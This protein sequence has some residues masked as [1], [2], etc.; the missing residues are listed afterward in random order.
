MGRSVITHFEAE[1][2]AYDT[3][4]PDEEYYKE[5]WNEMDAEEQEDYVD[6]ED[7]MYSMWN[8]DAQHA[9]EA[10]KEGTRERVIELWGSF[11]ATERATGNYGSRDEQ[12]V[13]LENAHSEVSI[14]EYCGV[15]AISLAPL[16]ST[17]GYP[18]DSSM[19]NLGKRWRA[20]IAAKFEDTL[21]TIHKLGNFSDGTSVYRSIAI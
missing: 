13:I 15:V 5:Y 9:W 3:L 21:G 17:Y 14:S 12:T 16:S 2:V 1:V 4:E 11:E 8:E 10:L 18:E 20:Q 6:F 7:F 19:E